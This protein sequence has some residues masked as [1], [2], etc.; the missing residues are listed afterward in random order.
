VSGLHS[1][2]LSF[3][4]TISSKDP[5]K[6]TVWRDPDNR[7]QFTEIRNSPNRSYRCIAAAAIQEI[8][9]QACIFA[10]LKVIDQAVSGEKGSLGWDAQGSQCGMEDLR[11]R[12]GKSDLAA[13]RYGVKER[14]N[15]EILEDR[16]ESG[17]ENWK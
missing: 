17:I 2:E 6:S 13:D 10:R 1:G 3:G 15:A 4:Q 9:D 16:V 5:R 11:L 7:K 12:L 8:G 14:V